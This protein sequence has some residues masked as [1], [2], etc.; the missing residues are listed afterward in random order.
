VSGVF[1]SPRPVPHGKAPAVAGSLVVVVALGVF[2]L[3]GWRVE[4]WGIAA[5]LWVGYLV[6]GAL[7]A[8]VPLG[9]AYLAA[10]GLVAVGRMSRAVVAMA[11]LIA[12]AVADADLGLPAAIV[13]ALAFTVEFVL[14][15]VAYFGGEAGT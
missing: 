13:Y 14:S 10:A 3:A 5:A 4:A 11:I 2:L 8:R 7:L 9:G 1:A 15:M 6:V 12:V